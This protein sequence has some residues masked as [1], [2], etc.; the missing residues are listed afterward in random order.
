M[1]GVQQD[2][3]VNPVLTVKPRTILG[4]FNVVH[5][6]QQVGLTYCYTIFSQSSL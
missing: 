1:P 3:S 6:T 2:P 4:K 5:K